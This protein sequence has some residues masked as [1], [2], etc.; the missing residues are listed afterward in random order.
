MSYKRDY[1]LR[2]IEMIGDLIIALL[3]KIKKGDYENANIQLEQIYFDFLKNDAAFFRLLPLDGMTEKLLNEHN[4]TNDH[5]HILAELF[6]VEA[7]LNNAKGDNKTSKSYYEKALKLY[8]H[9]DTAQK[10]Y[11]E[12]RVN[13]IKL[14]HEKIRKIE[15]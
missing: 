9:I 6:F 15:A 11:D 12:K 3:G 5:L 10:T 2:M 4:Y 14:I 7:E 8:D 13:K 1:L